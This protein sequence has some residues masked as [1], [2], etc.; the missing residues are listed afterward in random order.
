VTDT[1]KGTGG[2]IRQPLSPL[3]YQR[4]L[5]GDVLS[6]PQREAEL[7]P[8]PSSPL[9]LFNAHI[10][11]Q[12]T[13]LVAPYGRL[14][15]LKVPQPPK[16]RKGGAKRGEVVGFSRE[17]RKRLMQLFGSIDADAIAGKAVF[18]TLTYAD[19]WAPDWETWKR[20]FLAFMKRLERKYPA[21]STIWRLE[22]Q[23]RGAPHWHLLCIGE[24]FIPWEWVVE[25]WR[26]VALHADV[27]RGMQATDVS[28]VAEWQ[29]AAYYVSKYIGKEQQAALPVAAGRVWGCRRQALL[30]ITLIEAT[31]D[32]VSCGNIKAG[33][34]RTMHLPEVPYWL[35]H[36][37]GGA[38]TM[39]PGKDAMLFL[40]C[41]SDKPLEWDYVALPD[42]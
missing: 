9:G 17:S 42:T 14:V 21:V 2:T 11:P 29:Q 16:A 38:W 33:L 32:P 4:N 7:D 3:P 19:E 37:H 40:K 22:F 6:T 5:W 15:V 35:A 18:I 26:S 13:I 27:N 39:M 30:P 20:D 34:I 24:P 25:T 36:G 31:L 12:P 23:V 1:K 8:E 41:W 10:C 28:G